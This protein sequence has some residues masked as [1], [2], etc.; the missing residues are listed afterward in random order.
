MGTAIF[1]AVTLPFQFSELDNHS[2]FLLN[3]VKETHHRHAFD[4]TP[5]LHYPNKNFITIHERIVLMTAHGKLGISLLAFLLLFSHCRADSP[6]DTLRQKA[7]RGDAESQVQLGDIYK[8]GRG[9]EKDNQEAVKWYRKAAEQGDAE[10]QHR[11]GGMYYKGLGVKQSYVEA[12]K[13]FK[14]AAEQGDKRSQFNVGMMYDNGL[15]VQQNYAEAVKW[16]KMAA[17]QKNADALFS[18]G[19]MYFLGEGV[20]QND[21]KAAT[22]FKKAADLGNVDALV[23]IGSMFRDG[24]GVG[25]DY[26]KAIAYW[27]VALQLN[28]DE[29]AN[30]NLLVALA[31]ATSEQYAEGRRQ[32]VVIF[33]NIPK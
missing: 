7:A 23:N 12:M 10:G 30:K 8:D 24:R 17:D 33:N 15:G 4:R 27:T 5:F 22:F 6:L 16:Y 19:L 1:N 11:L 31:D 20:A 13:W 2:F 3:S 32:A 26:V 29:T 25:K 18:L 14:K 28:N 21:A 9:V